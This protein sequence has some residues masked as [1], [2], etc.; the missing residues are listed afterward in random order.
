M[1]WRLGGGVV[2]T[3]MSR[4]PMSENCSVRGIGVAD[5][6]SV[7]MVVRISRIFSFAATPNFCSSSIISNPKSLKTTSLLN[8]RCV[9]MRMSTLPSL[10][11]FSVSLIS[12]VVR[13]RL[14]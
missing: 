7:S 4:A 12:F 3:E 1:G 11:L 5:I 6:V 13:N 9:P 10:T 14:I 2:M 8:K